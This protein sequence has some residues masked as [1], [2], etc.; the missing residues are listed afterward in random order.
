MEL[1]S[2]AA[3]TS[4]TWRQTTTWEKF[5]KFASG[6]I[7]QVQGN[8]KGRNSYLKTI[9]DVM[10]LVF[11]ETDIS[12]SDMKIVAFYLDMAIMKN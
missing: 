3:W 1:F 6:T 5:G 10:A 11:S 4:F 9:G 8:Q 7:I 12:S 2:A